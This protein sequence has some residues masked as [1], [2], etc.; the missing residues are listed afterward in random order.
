MNEIMFIAYPDATIYRDNPEK[1]GKKK[2]AKKVLWGDWV[3][4]PKPED[5]SKNYIKVHCRGADGYIEKSK[6]QEERILEVNFMDVGQGDGT[7]IVVPDKTKPD[8]DRFL[9]IG[10]GIGDNMHQF[11]D[12][13]F[14]LRNNDFKVPIEYAFITHP[15]AD[16]YLGFSQLFDNPRYTFGKIYHNGVM[17]RNGKPKLGKTIK[18]GKKKYLL[19]IVDT[20]AKLMALIASQKTLKPNDYLSVLKSAKSVPKKPIPTEMA[21]KGIAI[22]GY[23]KGDFRIEVLGPIPETLPGGQKVL[24]VFGGDGPT[25]NG[26]SIA[27][28]LIYKNV[29]VF[30]SGD[31]NKNSQR[32]IADRLVKDVD[33]AKER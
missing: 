22:P 5:V 10:A 16:H 28:M 12:W 17:P 29:K 15:D 11:L 3:K 19:D 30:M 8:K 21:E 24:P 9:L 7:F 1:Q 6:L 23:T 32:Y 33:M 18:S 2:V 27:L 31:L 4:I 13:R 25:K 20:D 14:N 26:N